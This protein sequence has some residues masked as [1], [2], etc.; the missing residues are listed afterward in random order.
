[1]AGGEREAFGPA[2]PTAQ[3][4]CF[5]KPPPAAPG[6]V[7]FH[8]VFFAATPFP[9]WRYALPITV[10]SLMWFWLTTL[11]LAVALFFPVNKMVWVVSVRRMERKLAR[12]T[13][14]EER[15]KLRRR[16]RILTSI[17]VVTFAFL[18][19]STVFPA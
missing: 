19:N 12:V 8:P 17:I 16:S 4:S 1:M 6:E 3:V 14:D 15:E 7:F 2:L 5:E 10:G 11:V 18:F 13:T 9:K